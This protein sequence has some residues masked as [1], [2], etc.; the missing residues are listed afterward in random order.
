MEYITTTDKTPLG[1]NYNEETKSIDFRLYSKNATKILLCIFD[2]P[3]GESPIMVLNMEKKENDIW[4]TSVK[5]Y[6][7][8][9][10]KKPV[11]YGYRVFGENWEYDENWEP[12]FDNGFLSKFDEKNNRFNPNKI[13]F[14]PYTQELSHLASDVNPGLNMFR[15]GS[16]FHLIDNAKWSIKSIYSPKKDMQIAKVS[17]RP[18][19]SEIIGEVHVKDLTQNISM[20]EKG[21]YKGAGIFAK[22][23]KNLGITMVE[24]LP[25][26][27]FDSKQNG[28]NHWGYMPLAYFSLAR[29]YAFDKTYGNLL[30]EFREMINEFHKNDIKVCMDMVYNHT[31]EGGLVGH[32][33]DD[34]NLLSYALIDNSS[35]YKTYSNGYY[36]S[37]SGCGNDFNLTNEGAYNLV[38]DSIVYWANQGVDAFR[39]DLAAA[40]LE[41][42]CDCEETY[43]AIDSLAGK[44]K[45]ELKKK[46]VSVVDDFNSA[47][48]GIV[49]IAEPWTCGGKNCYQLGKFP[50]YWAEWNDVSR[51][52]IRKMTLYPNQITP[53]QVKDLIEGTPSA[54]NGNYKAVNYIA[55][56][57]GFTLFDLNTFNSKNPSTQGGSDWEICGNYDNDR[58]RKENAIRKQLIFLFL[59][60]GI[61]MIQIGDI[62]MHT[63]N[64]NNNSYNKDDGINYLN[65]DRAIKKDSFE[66]R[67]MEFIR[68]LIKFRNENKIFTHKNFSGCTT[69]HYDNG[70]IADINNLGYWDNGNEAFF[71]CLIN[72][73]KENIEEKRLYIASNSLNTSL[74]IL[75]PDKKEGKS[76]HICMDTSLFYIN[77]FETKNYIEKEYVLNPYA[78]AVF[79]EL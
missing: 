16:N 70:Q 5:D 24:F 25:I 30:N 66:N 74:K 78:L 71:G 27:E 17:P 26:N 3:E 63:K 43:S 76:W 1:A 53:M 15:S 31:G 41:C 9:C 36:R 29:K 50:S 56:H 69:Y 62:I 18:F 49:L 51:D 11:F 13:A 65:W 54:F 75:L 7:L 52:T 32:N 47:K 55:S 57:D 48:D 39:F 38:V 46:G 6:V 19:S 4:H 67:T 12:G 33:L 21:T 45:D 59:S 42:G 35:Y 64:G 34:A 22:S 8:N 61:P 37:N 23:I 10:H 73:D 60:S 77:N 28:T 58:Y 2:K 40:L 44:L 14:D 72:S 79:M 68:S 20:P